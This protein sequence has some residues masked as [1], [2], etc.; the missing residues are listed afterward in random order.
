MKLPKGFIECP[1]GFENGV[2]TTWHIGHVFYFSTVV[3]K[4]VDKGLTITVKPYETVAEAYLR[5]TG[6]ELK[7]LTCVLFAK[8]FYE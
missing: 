4:W 6:E 1:P 2:S 8:G 5:E 7:P 3:E